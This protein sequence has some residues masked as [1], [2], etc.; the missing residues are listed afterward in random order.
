L[1]KSNKAMPIA[2]DRFHR[3][4]KPNVFYAAHP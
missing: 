2:P 1:R 4:R 3:T